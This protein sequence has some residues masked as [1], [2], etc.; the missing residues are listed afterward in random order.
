MIWAFGAEGTFPAIE[1]KWAHEGLE[2]WM[3]MEKDGDPEKREE[4]PLA[5]W[6]ACC[7]QYQLEAYLEHFPREQILVSFL[8]DW[9][10]GKDSEV[11]RITRF[12]DL[13]PARYPQLLRE[14]P[15][16]AEDRTIVRS[17]LVK[18]VLRSP[19]AMQMVRSLPRSVRDWARDRIPT[20][21]VVLPEPDL[22]PATKAEFLE[23]VRPDAQAFLKEWGKPADFW[24]FDANA[25]ASAPAKEKS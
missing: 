6:D 9:R 15:H 24:S 18:Q 10:A 16:R 23:F 1:T 22:T 19:M 3:R 21:P 4:W 5:R 8:E 17:S 7:Y 14:K 25:K 2:Y 12:V 11:E 13:D 20:S